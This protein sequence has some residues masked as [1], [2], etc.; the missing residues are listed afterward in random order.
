MSW[1]LGVRQR[2]CLA[3][4]QELTD[5]YRRPNVE[6]PLIELPEILRKMWD[7]GFDKEHEARKARIEAEWAQEKEATAAQLSEAK[8][9]AAAGDPAAQ[10][11]V[12]L[13]EALELLGRAIRASQRGRWR[14]PGAPKRRPVGEHLEGMLNPSRIVAELHKRGLIERCGRFVRLTPSG[15]AVEVRQLCSDT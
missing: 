14:S 5:K 8:V 1:G 3:A 2:Q 4:T 13:H 15:C 7:D 6:W 12:E 11:R 9:K 10:R